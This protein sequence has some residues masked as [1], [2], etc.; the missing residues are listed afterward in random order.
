MVPKTTN[1]TAG[2]T[3]FPEFARTVKRKLE[4]SSTGKIVR[5][6][7]RGGVQS[8]GDLIKQNKLFYYILPDRVVCFYTSRYSPD[9]GQGFL[10]PMIN[11]F[12]EG[13]GGNDTWA[14]LVNRHDI[15]SVLPIRDKQTGLPKKFFFADAKY[16]IVKGIVYVFDNIED[17]NP[18]RCDEITTNLIH[19]ASS[20][21]KVNI[22]FGGNSACFDVPGFTS[23]DEKFLPEDVANLAMTSY[24]DAIVDQTFFQDEALVAKYFGDCNDVKALFSDLFGI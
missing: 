21:F 22:A 7:K 16:Y 5:K 8:F 3:P 12:S 24:R 19:E 10:Q 14:G 13:L 1:K 6:V 2:N 18:T 11:A 4:F 23:L 9:G 20:T 17:A 15:T